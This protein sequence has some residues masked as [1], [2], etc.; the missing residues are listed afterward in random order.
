MAEHPSTEWCNKVR[1]LCGTSRIY[2]PTPVSSVHVPSGAPVH[3]IT[4]TLATITFAE[5]LLAEREPCT[6]SDKLLDIVTNNP[7]LQATPLP[8]HTL[9]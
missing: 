1:A 6:L 8:T 5:D 9:H 4:N 7:I 2:S 3:G